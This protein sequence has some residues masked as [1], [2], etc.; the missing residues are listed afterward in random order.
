V[1]EQFWARE[2]TFFGETVRIPYTGNADFL[3]F[4]LDQL[5]GANALKGLRGKGIAA[6]PFTKVEQL[7]S[8][9][10]KRLRAQRA[11]LEKRYKE[12]QDKLKDVRTKGADG[13]I[14][15]TAEQQTAVVEFTRELLRIRREQ[16]AVQF[17]AR[18]DYESLDRTMKLVNIGAVPVV[19]GLIALVVG[20]VRYQRR[21]R[22]H[23]TS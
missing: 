6:R 20:L 14:E 16:R 1:Q 17:E 21:R 8:D 12:I 19:V 11:D 5:S 10:E 22:R 4:A 23:E 15:L 3:M 18:R 2:Q 7:Q 9:A 13:K